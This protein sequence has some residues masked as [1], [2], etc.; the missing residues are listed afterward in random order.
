MQE[1][2]NQTQ[3]KLGLIE[4]VKM[5][6]RA[7]IKDIAQQAGVSLGAVHCALNGKPGVGED[8]RKRILE[9]AK[10]CN[11]KPNLA[12]ASLKR[13]SVRIAVVFPD[14]VG[15]NRFYV[16]YL[17]AGF[18]DYLSIM[19]DFNIEV[20][21]IPFYGT[22]NSLTEE[23][24]CLYDSN[25]IHGMICATGYMDEQGKTAIRKFMERE[26]PI[27]LV[28]EDLMDSGK[29]CCV[30][31][32]YEVIGRTVAELLSREIPRGGSILVCAG[33]AS[34]PS[35]YKVVLGMEAY[36]KEKRFGNKIYKIHSPQSEEESIMQ[37]E[38]Y[39]E[40]KDDIKACFAVTAR[41]SV[42][43]GKALLK[44]NK[45]G[46]INSVGSDMFIE[47]KDFLKEGVFTNLINK[48]PFLQSY[49]ATKYLMEYLMKGKRPQSDTIYVGSEIV[50]QSSLPMYE[51]DGQN[52]LFL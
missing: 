7:T 31:P 16:R 5:E 25:S 23:L 28:G 42:Q 38:R 12:A 37:I 29:L 33:D 8:T 52:R 26:I 49:T 19:K 20:L 46:F 10:Q 50:F 14:V 34:V 32:N 48:N 1:L 11:Y 22:S 27:A 3:S 15:Y 9:I 35:H 21:E 36:M 13:K 45:A 4:G 43:L 24:E 41:S 39:L 44:T 40:E 30:Q 6:K 47:N 51:I 17:W 18:Q 2:Y